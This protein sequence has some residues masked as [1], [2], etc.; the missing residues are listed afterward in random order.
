MASQFYNPFEPNFDRGN[1][2]LAGGFLEFFEVNTNTHQPTYP[3]QL[4]ATA[5]DA[6]PNPVTLGDDGRPVVETWTLDKPYRITQRNSEGVLLNE[7]KFYLPS[8]TSASE[9]VPGTIYNLNDRVRSA[10]NT[11]LYV[12]LIDDNTTDPTITPNADWT[13]ERLIRVWNSLETYPV[14]AVVIYTDNIIYTSLVNNN[15]NN[16][17]SSSGTSWFALRNQIKGGFLSMDGASADDLFVVTGV[18]FQPTNITVY[19]VSADNTANAAYISS[20]F[21]AANATD[22]RAYATLVLEDDADVNANSDDNAL[23]ALFNT[24]IVGIVVA[25]ESFDSDG[26]TLKATFVSG[27]VDKT[28]LIWVARG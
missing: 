11:L 28:R 12:S 8:S 9:F 7:A 6:N 4:G 10:D 23:L 16:I 14:D 25:L 20:G 5:T 13:Q 21:G 19:G 26:F 1:N 15:L 24:S 18:G 17:P 2:V 22:D 27:T 3:T